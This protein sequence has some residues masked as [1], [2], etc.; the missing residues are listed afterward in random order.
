MQRRGIEATLSK[1]EMPRAAVGI[2]QAPSEARVW[3]LKGGV[4][5][6]VAHKVGIRWHPGIRKVLLPIRNE[7]G[8]Y[9]GTLAR[10]VDGSKPKYVM[11]NGK[12]AFHM[13]KKLAGPLVL[14]EDVL[15]A[16]AY[17]RAGICGVA[18]LGTSMD[19]LTAARLTSGGVNEVLI[20]LDPDNAGRLAVGK[21]RKALALSPVTVAVLHPRLDPK[22]LPVSELKQLVE[23]R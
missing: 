12:P 5:P 11:L 21:V 14:T 8:E 19:A 22:Y 15:S 9:T 20:S 2:D 4:R 23:Q 18:I 16:M 3:L 6:E 17:A 10:A 7:R 1:V 13:P